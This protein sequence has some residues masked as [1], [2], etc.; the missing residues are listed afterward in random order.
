MGMGECWGVGMWGGGKVLVGDGDGGCEWEG[1]GWI[2]REDVGKV[3]E[4][5]VWMGR[6]EIVMVDGMMRYVDGEEEG[7]VGCKNV[8]V[9]DVVKEESGGGK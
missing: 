9:G 8:D 3:D 5:E 6:I 7:G 1:G 2:R 4:C